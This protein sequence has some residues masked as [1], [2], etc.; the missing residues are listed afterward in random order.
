VKSPP[1]SFAGWVRLE[2]S[3]WYLQVSDLMNE[4]SAAVLMADDAAWQ[5]EVSDWWHRRPRIWRRAARRA[6]LTEEVFLAAQAAR[7][8]Q[9]ST[10]LRTLRPLRD[11]PS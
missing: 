1:P 3:G 6:W 8:V 10:R 11:V 9:A 7:L 2:S 4:P 5:F